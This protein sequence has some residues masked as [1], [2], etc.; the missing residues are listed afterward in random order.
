MGGTIQKDFYGLRKG[1]IP[2]IEGLENPAPDDRM[3]KISELEQKNPQ[4]SVNAA[5]GVAYPLYKNIN[6][7]TTVGWAYYFDANNKYKTIYSDRPHQLDLNLGL[8]YDF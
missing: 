6:I 3:K 7:Y 2:T 8:R 1:K 4:F 5:L